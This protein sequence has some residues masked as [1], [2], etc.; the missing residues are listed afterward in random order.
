MLVKIPFCVTLMDKSALM[1]LCNH[2]RKDMKRNV[3]IAILMLAFCVSSGQMFAGELKPGTKAP[4]WRLQSPEGKE[5]SSATYEGKVI[6]LNFWA[7]WCPP[8]VAEIP[9]FI[10]LQKEFEDKE[11]TFVGISLDSSSTPVKR[12]IKRNKVNY[13]IV[14]GDA[15]V[16]KDFGNFTGIPHT[17]V[18]DKKG[19]IQMSHVGQISKSKLSKSIKPLL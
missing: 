16:V 14:M 2:I 5:M 4:A 6:V 11:F 3:C 19:M 13:P 18:I 17:Y 8:C 7:T 15:D 1:L 9:D 12:Y 10:E